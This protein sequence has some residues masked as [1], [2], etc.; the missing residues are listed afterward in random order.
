MLEYQI[1]GYLGVPAIHDECER[2]AALPDSLHYR[3]DV[4][5]IQHF[6]P[7]AMLLLG[8]ALR[9]LEKRSG[10]KATVEVLGRNDGQLQGHNYAH[11]MGFWWSIGQESL[12]PRPS[13]NPGG[14]TI[15]I[16]KLSYKDLFH[17]SGRLDPV[18]SG[19]VSRAASEAATVLCGGCGATPLWN[20]LEYSF[21]EVF[22]NAFEH[23]RSDL[24][25]YTA[26]S[27]ST[28]DDIQLAILDE[29]VGMLA[30]LQSSSLHSPATDAE[31]IELALKAGVSRNN[32]RVR[33]P[34]ETNRL[35]E[36]F[37]GQDPDVWDNTGYGLTGVTSLCGEAG[38]YSIASGNACRSFSHATICSDAAHKGTALRFVIQ[39]SRVEE[40]LHKVGLA[41]SEWP[42][43]GSSRSLMSESQRRRLELDDGAGTTD[44]YD[45]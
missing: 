33:T 28:K 42:R 38:Q 1:S 14:A 40:A 37:P 5:K 2:L 39:P 29:G 41:G 17:A 11:R 26:S 35:R 16:T 19:A 18:R 6:E 7:F 20:A 10:G 24:V 22:R 25:W 45:V 36:Q 9:C 12:A 44:R 13:S 34:E 21:R 27:R 8:A 4:S 3:I 30:S 43:K 32:G 31:A 23:S 15:P